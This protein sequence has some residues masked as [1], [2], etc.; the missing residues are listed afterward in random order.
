MLRAAATLSRQPMF[1]DTGLNAIKPSPQFPHSQLW[2][3]SKGRWKCYKPW[4]ATFLWQSWSMNCGHTS[5][6][7][8][9]L[10]KKPDIGHRH[11]E[12]LISD[13]DWEWCPEVSLNNVPS[14]VQP[15][16]L[17]RWITDVDPISSRQGYHGD[18]KFGNGM[19]TV[20]WT[21]YENWST[22]MKLTVL[23]L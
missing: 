11:S 20:K 15:S 14:M 10:F 19:W 21:V 16:W 18:G 6:M 13:C 4:K 9:V 17:G 3:E 22:K 8:A 1:R 12:E 2:V 7:E 23:L 5:S